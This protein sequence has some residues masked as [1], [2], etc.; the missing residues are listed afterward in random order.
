MKVGIIGGGASGLMAAISAAKC[1]HEVTIFEHM[2][3]C[4]KKLLLTG[5]GKCNLT[6]T[7]MNISHYHGGNPEFAFRIINRFDNNRTLSFF[8]DLGLM[9]KERNGYYYPYQDQSSAVLDVLRFKLRNLNVKII[10]ECDVLSVS[11]NKTGYSVKTSAGDFFVDAVIIAAGSAAAPK[12][13]SNGSGYEIAK[14]L[15]HNVIKPL[16]A[17][18]QLRC[19]EDFFA[20][21]AG[22]R[23]QGRVTVRVNGTDMASDTGEIQLNNYGISGIPVMQV[24]H[25]AAKSLDEGKNVTASIC[26]LPKLT[27]DNAKSVESVSECVGILK[28]RFSTDRI[29]TCEES[30]IGLFN[31]NLGNCILKRCNIKPGTQAFSLNDKQIE[32][33]A[34]MIMNFEVNICAANGFNE[35]QVCQGGVDITE[36][37]DCLE[38]LL[39]KNLYF[40]GEILDVHAD[41][42]GYNLQ[43][44]WSSGYVAGRLGDI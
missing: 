16:P 6:N 5:S 12:S 10:T 42:G 39:H 7:D 18:T 13:G 32:A 36:V 30:L 33:L 8:E 27:R 38:S 44:A 37:S 17:L 31:K 22:I 20:S 3:K 4:G 2:Q 1:N 28:E 19:S 15:G 29:R 11:N 43:W 41:C 9:V 34:R 14:S 24:S 40:C 23:C 21:L 25:I 26:F 35:A